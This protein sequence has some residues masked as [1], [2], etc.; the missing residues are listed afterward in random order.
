MGR[1]PYSPGSP[2][3]RGQRPVS[4][5]CP[6]L[7]RLLN[8]PGRR[9]SARRPAPATT[10]S[11]S[12]SSWRSSST[13]TAS[14][15]R[16]STPLIR[17]DL[18]LSTRSR[19]AWCSRRSRWP[20][21]SSRSRPGTSG[22]RMGARRVLIRVVLWWS[23]FTAATGWVWNWLSLFD[24]AVPLRRRRSRVLP[25]HRPRL[26]PMAAADERVRAQGIL[27]MARAGAARSRRCCSS[28]VLQ[29]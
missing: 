27:W 16:W 20:T 4:A 10:S 1:Q 24:R 29:L 3:N 23:F 13:S 21:R 22:D 14:P 28:C 5:R 7:F 26:Q 19:W 2:A 25:E 18:G 11:S 17:L 8:A 6:I 15:S 12:R 9:R